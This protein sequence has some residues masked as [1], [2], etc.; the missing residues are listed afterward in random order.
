MWNSSKVAEL[1]D[2]IE[3]L[4]SGQNSVAEEIAINIIDLENY[5][6]LIGL[7]TDEPDT[8]E[9]L[10]NALNDKQKTVLK[11]VEG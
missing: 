10:K 7:E 6:V 1:C 3:L 8:A 4:E 9:E 2:K 11:F 5:L